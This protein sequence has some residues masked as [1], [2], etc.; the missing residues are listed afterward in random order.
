MFEDRR[1]SQRRKVRMDAMLA[2]T[3]KEGEERGGS[4]M[5]RDISLHG[6]Y[7]VS[8]VCP[9]IG[10]AIE[11]LL[12]WPQRGWKGERLLKVD[13]KVVRHQN[14]SSRVWGVAAD[15]ES[16]PLD[17][18]LRGERD[19]LTEELNQFRE[20]SV[21]KAVPVDLFADTPAKIEELAQPGVEHNQSG[22]VVSKELKDWVTPGGLGAEG[23]VAADVVHEKPVHHPSGEVPSPPETP[24]QPL[25]PIPDPGLFVDRET[26][27]DRLRIF[28]DDASQHLFVLTG[29]RGIGKTALLANAVQKFVQDL[30]LVFWHPFREEETPSLDTLFFKLRTFFQ[31]HG[32]RSLFDVSDH[33]ET[34]DKVNAVISAFLRR[35]YYL[36]FDDLHL[37]L[38]RDHQMKDSQLGRLFEGLLPGGYLGKVV[39]GSRIRP[40]FQKQLS[41]VEAEE[42]KGL[43]EEVSYELMRTFG[44]RSDSP[45][46]LRTVYERTEGHPEAIRLLSN[47]QEKRPLERL[48]EDVSSWGKEF[49]DRFFKMVA[50]EMEEA[51]RA[52]LL[53]AATHREPISEKVFQYHVEGNSFLTQSGSSLDP[54]RRLVEGCVF[55]YEAGN[56]TYRLHGLVKEHFVRTLDR[57]LQWQ[58]HRKAAEYY[59]SL[60]RLKEPV[61]RDQVLGEVEASYHHFMGRQY[62]KAAPFRLSKYFLRWG[63]HDL[64]MQMWERVQDH[65]EGRK[66]ANCTNSMGLI[67]AA[68][69]EYDKALE[70]Y[71][72]SEK[73]RQEVGD[74][75]GLGTVYNNIGGIYQARGEHQEALK[76]YLK[77]E[78]ITK[79]R[80]D[81]AGLGPTYNNIGLIYRAQGE[82]DKALESYRKS[83][84]IRR[85]VGDQV[86]LGT[87][88]N[89]IG[90]IEY[91]RGA[92]DKAL[93]SY[94][95]SEKIR[96]E[97]GDQAG[98]GPTYRDQA[99]LGPTYSNIGLILRAQG[100]YDEALEY[101]LKSEKIRKEVG[102]KPGL[103][104]VYSNIGGIY[105]VRKEYDKA[106]EY[107]L[108]DEQIT[109]E[110]GDKAG[111]GPA[112]NNIGLLYG[113]RKEYDKALEYFLKSKKVCKEVGDQ[114]GLGTVYSNIGGIHRARSE[115][116]EAM[117]HLERAYEILHRIGVHGEAEQVKEN[118]QALI[119][120]RA[121]P[122]E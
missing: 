72:K 27:L 28:F 120:E 121:H 47:L 98:L 43:P 70:S 23:A 66:L 57:K 96:R 101:F 8:D 111:L 88:Y 75:A 93:E 22:T 106:L 92:H 54:L 41:G 113:D 87:V 21:D 5:V 118:I 114:A 108:K 39:V 99:G 40:A 62:E 38:D 104:A 60:P 91:A 64:H 52:V 119:E 83:E 4:V 33:A 50:K 122:K 24:L 25:T 76:Y 69:G 45:E 9:D 80:G 117:K 29:L 77:S 61:S 112:Y 6:V 18:S 55:S 86:G 30:S 12:K 115:Y 44:Y 73:I 42:V 7:L 10:C 48:L 107:Y 14:L 32:D 94:R 103:G 89:N 116:P 46:I 63:L 85:E 49:Q 35:K 58:A 71:R 34:E 109:K 3:N 84:K 79:K 68:Q 16:S 26:H 11:L 37:L 110:V 81:Q 95:K 17:R 2:F 36:I 90:G 20:K 65:L 102:D 67:Y 59:D 97:V 100:A 78:Q 19:V 13:A 56:K 82:Y 105:R 74:Q 1:R 51:E 15:F 53:V 31:G